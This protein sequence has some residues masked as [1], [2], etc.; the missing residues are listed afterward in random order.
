MVL[1]RASILLRFIAMVA[2]VVVISSSCSTNGSTSASAA[3]VVDVG[4]FYVSHDDGL[5]SFDKYVWTWT[6]TTPCL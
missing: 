5:F 6:L 1:T 4:I 3:S 2:A